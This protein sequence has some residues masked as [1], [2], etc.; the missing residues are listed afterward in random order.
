MA[1][2]TELEP[3]LDSTVAAI[4]ENRKRA[5]QAISLINTAKTAID[6]LPAQFAG[7]ATAVNAFVAANPGD[8]AAEALGARKDFIA[9]DYQALASYLADLKTAAEGV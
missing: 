3:L 8:V 1:T 7:T 4:A 2:Y 6:A 9:S 5:Q